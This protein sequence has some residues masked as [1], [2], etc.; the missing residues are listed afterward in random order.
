M[1]FSFKFLFF[2][3][4]VAALLTA[5]LVMP[6]TKREQVVKRVNE[7]ENAK[8]ELTESN[9]HKNDPRRFFFGE[10]A[11]RRIR[12]IAFPY[13]FRRSPD[14]PEFAGFNDEEGSAKIESI[15]SDWR[16]LTHLESLDL[17]TLHPVTSTTVEQLG[18][19]KAL[20]FAAISNA[21]ITQ[22]GAAAIGKMEN[23]EVLWL[24]GCKF[25]AEDFSSLANLEH[26]AVILIILGEDDDESPPSDQ[27]I[28]S[29]RAAADNAYIQVKYSYS[30][31]RKKWAEHVAK[32]KAAK[33]P[34]INK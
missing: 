30:Y 31:A 21:D 6:E 27:C 2:V 15:I 34:S 23:L 5:G 33:K 17:R 29:M 13:R 14:K 18:R 20:R 3:V 12:K 11:G 1:R 24:D 32:I 19:L 22:A 16:A 8:L 7:F 10:N 4:F 26:L 25:S 9:L 28:S